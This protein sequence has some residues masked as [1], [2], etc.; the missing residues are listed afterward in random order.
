MPASHGPETAQHIAD[1]YDLAGSISALPGEVDA[2]YRLTGDRGSFVI[3]LSPPDADLR[4]LE[5]QNAAMQHLAESAESTPTP[6]P[7]ASR[8]GKLIETLPDGGGYARVLTYLPGRPYAALGRPIDLAARVGAAVASLTAALAGFEHDAA[9][10]T[11]RWDL[12]QATSVIQQGLGAIEG[13]RRRRMVASIL[14]ELAG[15]ADSLPELPRQ[16]IHNDANDLNVLVEGGRVSGIID[17]GD[18]VETFRV[19]DVAIAATYAMLDQDDPLTVAGQLVGGYCRVLPLEVAEAR[20]I[21]RLVR[22]RLATSVV[23]SAQRG[24]VNPHHRVSEHPAWDLIE[25][26]DTVETRVATAELAAAAGARAEPDPAQPESLRQAR[27]ERIGPSLG[28]S[29][30]EPLTIVGGRDTYLF[31]QRGR[32]YLDCVNNVC[33]VGHGHPGVVAAASH[34]MERLNTNT[35][36][37]HP[38]LV[39][40]ARRLTATLPDPLAVCYFVNSGSEASE[41]ALR[42][43]QTA[44]GARDMVVIDHAYH[45]QTSALVELSPYKFDGPGGSGR[46]DW[47]HV[48]PIPDPYRSDF[49]GSDAAARY[50]AAMT[51]LVATLERPIAGIIAEPVLGCAGQVVPEPGVLAAAFDAVSSVGGVT[52]ADEVQ[53]GFGRVGK[54]FWGFELHAV[55]PDIVTMGKPI[56]NGHPLGAVVTTRRLADSFDNGMEYFNTFGG[57]PVSCAVGLAVLDAI[58]EGG[59]QSHAAVVGDH[60]I[61]RLRELQQVHQ[62][63]GDVRGSGLFIGVELVD[64]RSEKTP[65]PTLAS[66]VV[67][68]AK[69]AGVLLSVDGVFRNVLKIKPP[70]TFTIAD[71][72]RM[73]AALDEALGEHS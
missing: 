41:L 71:A 25:R 60:L 62:A 64:D 43:A 47:V 8:A 13:A 22:A 32:R 26:L 40:Y 16:V 69:D 29:Y 52:I 5:L 18:V 39:D 38:A 67:E 63:I 44:T 6:V 7:V 15:G 58:E 27:R 53:V 31:D 61:A 23:T 51:D 68:H 20:W 37:L 56:G 19:A 48:A 59:L 54:A 70:M 36:Y 2:N 30:H 9:R 10:R 11:H 46:P 12:A 66:R 42:I 21:Y 49:R 72:D 35:R 1:R 24:G 57:N 14:E 45:G 33:H 73:T 50:R 55:V 17:F 4:A 65:A 28:L 34:Q 3:R